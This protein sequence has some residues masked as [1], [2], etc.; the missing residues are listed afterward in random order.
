MKQKHSPE[1]WAIPVAN[2][3]RIA[4]VTKKAV[5]FEALIDDDPWPTVEGD[6][7]TANVE[8]VIK[9][10]NVMRGIRHPRAFMIA[11]RGL[12]AYC[13][14]RQDVLTTA[15]RKALRRLIKVAGPMK[16]GWRNV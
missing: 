6:E 1:P 5:L 15:Q 11:V 3:F 13:S 16:G 4:S 14:V 9:C 7:A 12:A 8:R 10:V 2:V